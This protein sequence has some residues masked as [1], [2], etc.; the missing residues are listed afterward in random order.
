[1]T[2]GG[3]IMK[4]LVQFA[5]LA[6]T[7]AVMACDRQPSNPISPAITG[8]SD[9]AADGSNLK[10]AAPTLASPA[11]GAQLQGGAQVVLTV[12]NVA[13]KYASFPVTFEIELR[14][15]SGTL[16]ANPRFSRS[17]GTTS[18]FT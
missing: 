18:S 17:S 11:N 5:L 7:A 9:A 4:R 16:V 2:S 15:P 14:N 12:N 6:L 13:G 8:D 10:I 3:S 1:M